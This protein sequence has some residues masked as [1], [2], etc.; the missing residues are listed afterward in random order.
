M[1]TKAGHGRKQQRRIIAR[2]RRDDACTGHIAPLP[3]VHHATPVG[4]TEG[5]SQVSAAAVRRVGAK[6]A[7]IITAKAV[8]AAHSA[9]LV[10]IGE[11]D[12]D[13][14]ARRHTPLEKVQVVA[15]EAARRAGRRRMAV[16]A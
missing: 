15:R 10:A 9:M 2:R 4:D 16:S 14:S 13:R 8:T 7:E 5:F 12:E 1:S 11:S 6:I 3:G